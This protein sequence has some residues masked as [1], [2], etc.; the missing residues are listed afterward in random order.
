M[1][2]PKP[3]LQS[4]SELKEYLKVFV[5]EREK[6]YKIKIEQRLYGNGDSYHKKRRAEEVKRDGRRRH[7]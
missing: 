5:K 6:L 3:D 7:V 1:S 2:V 4:L